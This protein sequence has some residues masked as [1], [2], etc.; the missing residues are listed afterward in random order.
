MPVNTLPRAARSSSRSRPAALAVPAAASSDAAEA[1]QAAEKAAEPEAT[2]EE[3]AVKPQEEGSE[4]V[5]GPAMKESCAA[6]PSA[7]AEAPNPEA[8]AAEGNDVGEEAAPA[9]ALAETSVAGELMREVADASDLLDPP[10]SN[11]SFETYCGASEPERQS[12]NVLV[13]DLAGPCDN[14]AEQSPAREAQG[15]TEPEA[16]GPATPP[17]LPRFL[18]RERCWLS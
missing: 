3:A 6:Q 14:H 9:Q 8:H 4:R 17:H 2:P 11:G 13:G 16:T 12:G 1:P 10:G 5:D 7:S 18:R 15:I